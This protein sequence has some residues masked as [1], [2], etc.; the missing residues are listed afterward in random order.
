[1]ADIGQR[2]AELYQQLSFPSAPKLQSALR[3][4]GITLPVSALK[5][6]TSESG[7]R[8]VLQPPPRYGGHITSG[9]IDD[10]W[11]ADLLSFESRPAK[12][13]DVTYTSVLLCQDIFSRYLW[14]EPISNKTQVRHAFEDILDKSQRK[15]REL[16]TD[17]GSEFT[18]REFQSMRVRRGIY[19]CGKVGLNNIA[20]LDCAMG[21]LKDMIAR[22]SADE[23]AGG[24]WLTE[25][26]TAVQ[27][28]NRL[29]H[30]A[31]HQHAP[32]EVAGDDDLRFQLR[33]ENAEKRFDN[34][35]TQRSARKSSKQWAPTEPCCN[36]RRSRDVQECPTGPMKCTQSHKSRPHR[37]RIRKATT[38]TPAWSCPFPRAAQRF[39]LQ[40]RQHAKT[41]AAP[42]L[43]GSRQSTLHFSRS[44]FSEPA[45]AGRLSQRPHEPWRQGRD[46]HRRSETSA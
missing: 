2:V 7:A 38:M 3:K 5:E 20:T 25:L 45:A 16:N 1:M 28:Y 27:C 9:R 14:A 29:D 41:S 12:R 10:R 37:L 6:L 11:A 13:G 36:R 8:Q 15:P 35:E 40:R 43:N 42:P 4:E 23:A 17:M 22:R 44:S 26:P 33:Y 30:N 46:S 21:T 34:I 24:D 39:C 18:S 19:H 32:A 31:L